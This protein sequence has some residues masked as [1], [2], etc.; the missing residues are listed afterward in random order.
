M[1]HAWERGATHAGF[2]WENLKRLLGTTRRRYEDNN[3]DVT[4]ICTMAG[5]RL[6]LELRIGTNDR[7][8]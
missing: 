1:W 2:R 5:C 7:L 3:T 8:L 4:E 6:L